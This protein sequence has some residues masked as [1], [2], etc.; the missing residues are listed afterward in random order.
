MQLFSRIIKSAT[1]PFRCTNVWSDSKEL[2][3]LIINCQLEVIVPIMAVG[4]IVVAYECYSLQYVR[5]V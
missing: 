3:H 5:T 2:S 4:C 1:D